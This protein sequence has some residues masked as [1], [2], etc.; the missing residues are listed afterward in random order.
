MYIFI[1]IFVSMRFNLILF[2]S[3]TLTF[4]YGQDIYLVKLKAKVI[5]PANLKLSQSTIDRRNKYNIKIDQFDYQIESE[6]IQKIQEIAPMLMQSKWLNAIAVIA[7]V[8]QIEKIKKLNFVS[9]ID[10]LKKSNTIKSKL[11]KFESNYTKEQYGNSYAQINMHQGNLMHDA[12]FLGQGMK[13]A[14]FDAGF[15]DVKNIKS[16]RHLQEENR[17]FSVRNLVENTSNV[18]TLDNHGTNVLGCL[19]SF[20]LDTIIA[21]APKAN[22][23]LFITEDPRSES[24]L[25]ELNWAVAAEMADSMGIDIINSSLGYNE[26][27]DPSQNYTKSQMDGKTTIISRAATIASQK[28]IIVVNSAGNMG[29]NSWRMI[30]AP[31][32]AIDVVTVG[33]VDI[34]KNI[35]SF[36]SRG[37]NAEN[38]VKPNLIAVG[39]GTTM[40]Y[41]DGNYSQG[42]GTSFSSPVM[43]GLIACFWQ[44]NKWM[45][46][47]EIKNLIYSSASHFVEPNEDWGFGIPE[48]K[49]IID[50][51]VLAVAN[52]ELSVY[53][54][55][56]KKSVIVE[57]NSLNAVDNSEI[58]VY[59]YGKVV[60]K[61]KISIKKGKNQYFV[62]IENLSKGL[63]FIKVKM[64]NYFLESKFEKL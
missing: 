29:N 46:P 4:M 63:Y 3:L 32:D 50:V 31:A 17:L 38:V 35:A 36:S 9:N 58:S 55:P 24:R 22:Y 1:T 15:T 39:W 44:K 57:L 30:T 23:Y 6:R 62:D 43:A 61:N 11:N 54:N 5:D 59:N 48:F 18:F 21:P 26:F 41:N 34:N 47:E 12:G 14:I 10:I 52:K 64:E 2:F 19:A 45:H 40:Y 8:D 16:L 7:T 20:I 53:P 56:T 37:Y 49:R 27:D 42:S 28:G 25:E 60:M 51:N 33:A 13:I